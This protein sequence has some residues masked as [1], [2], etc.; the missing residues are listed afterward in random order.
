MRSSPV[1]FRFILA[2]LSLLLF[3]GSAQACEANAPAD[4]QKRQKASFDSFDTNGD[5][6]IS[7]EEY[8][9]KPDTSMTVG[10]WQREG[11]S[12]DAIFKK[13]DRDGSGSLSFKEWSLT[14]VLEDY[15][16]DSLQDAC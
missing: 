6:A 7:L 3:A 16:V 2:V 1:S 8:K 4:L 9:A 11:L 14:H 12:P 15:Y 5:G 10:E 13:M